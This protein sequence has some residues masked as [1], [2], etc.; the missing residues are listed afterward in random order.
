M[1]PKRRS[2]WLWWLAA[3]ALVVAASS[4]AAMSQHQPK[5]VVL[6]ATTT[7][8]VDSTGSAPTTTTTAPLTMMAR[9][10]PTELTIPA[11][12]VTTSVGTLGMQ[13]DGT[14]EVPSSAQTTGW[15]D[16]GPAPGQM[17]SAVILGHVDSYL[18]PGKFF[19]LKLLKAGDLIHVTAA[20]GVVVTFSVNRVVEYSKDS[21]PDQLVYGPHGTIAL[22]LVTCGGVFDHATGHYLSNIVVYSTLASSAGPATAAP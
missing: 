15:Y 4:F 7:T 9:S 21:F 8:V 2:H 16:G 13:S 6:S 3:A 10:R 14:V 19:N 17:G 1:T 22:Q 20:D 18:G 5:I 12:G 11:I